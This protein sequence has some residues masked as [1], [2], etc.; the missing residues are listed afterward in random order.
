MERGKSGYGLCVLISRSDGIACS[1]FGHQ[2]L[3]NICIK[4][5]T[6]MQWDVRLNPLKSQLARFVGNI[7][8]SC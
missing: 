5:G 3:I 7:L 8:S 2:Q 1:R 4:Y 6:G